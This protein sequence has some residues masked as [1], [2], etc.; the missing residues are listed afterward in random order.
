MDKL[1]TLDELDDTARHV[2]NDVTGQSKTVADLAR[3]LADARA[4]AEAAEQRADRAELEY[5]ATGDGA[6]ESMRAIEVAARS[7][8][9]R[10]I[11]NRLMRRHV[12]AEHIA[13][14]EHA[15]RASRWGEDA[16]AGCPRA[17]P[18]GPPSPIADTLITHN[19][20]GYHRVSGSGAQTITLFTVPATGPRL[21]RRFTQ[22]PGGYCASLTEAIAELNDREPAKLAA[23]VG[24]DTADTIAA[25]LAADTHG[26][27]P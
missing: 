9:S 24:A 11:V 17:L 1:L 26:A 5:A 20:F 8:R 15:H 6:A 22:R 12:E 3:Q 16:V 23:L 4:R 21:R 2:D 25:L 7:G 13:E 14:T 18:V 19:V 27:Q 10:T